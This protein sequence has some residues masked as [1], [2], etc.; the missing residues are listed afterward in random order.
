MDINEFIDKNRAM[1]DELLGP[2][3]DAYAEISLKGKIAKELGREEAFKYFELWE[4]LGTTTQDKN[5]KMRDMLQHIRSRPRNVDTLT[6]EER[7]E[8]LKILW[9]EFI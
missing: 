8:Y 9:E 2:N 7:T 5:I 3:Q 4:R 1:I 6:P